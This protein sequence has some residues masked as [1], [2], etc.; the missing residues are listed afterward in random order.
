[1][2]TPHT[3]RHCSRSVDIVSPAVT[4]TLTMLGSRGLIG[5]CMVQSFGFA[6]QFSYFGQFFDVIQI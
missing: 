2:L 3:N 5:A 6:N 1:M 4:H